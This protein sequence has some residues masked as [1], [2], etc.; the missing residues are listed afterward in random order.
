MP[1]SS[2]RAPQSSASGL[3]SPTR[4]VQEGCVK[5]GGSD[6]EYRF[7]A[8]GRGQ[9]VGIYTPLIM[10]NVAAAIGHVLRLQVKVQ[11]LGVHVIVMVLC[12]QGM[13][14]CSLSSRQRWTLILNNQWLTRTAIKL[15]FSTYCC[16]LQP[17]ASIFKKPFISKFSYL[18]RQ[19]DHLLLLKSTV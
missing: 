7:I 13:T 6:D 3:V 10:I 16:Q 1:S 2:H 4:V 15:Q 11:R 5:G 9:C 12:D 8:V 17:N 19:M 18:L 14:C